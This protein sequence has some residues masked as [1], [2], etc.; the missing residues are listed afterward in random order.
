[1]R[2]HVNQLSTRATKNVSA[3]D[4]LISDVIAEDLIKNKKERELI[5][6]IDAVLMC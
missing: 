1:M 5:A 4:L 6:V 2:Y 3:S